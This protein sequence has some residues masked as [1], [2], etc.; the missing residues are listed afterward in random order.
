MKIYTITI[1]E[2]FVQSSCLKTEYNT[3]TSTYQTAYFSRKKAICVAKRLF[4]QLKRKTSL[5][6]I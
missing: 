6:K 1:L 4:E 3:T 2:Q 5:K